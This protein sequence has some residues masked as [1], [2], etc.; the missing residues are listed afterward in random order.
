MEVE[1]INFEEKSTKNISFNKVDL[2]EF[3]PTL[4]LSKFKNPSID[5]LKDYGDG[6]IKIDQDSL[7]ERL[8]SVCHYISLLSDS[9]AI[10]QYKKIKGFSI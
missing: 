8:L 3:D 5:I 4:D 7:Y 9:Q 1:E 6:T 2:K 10:I